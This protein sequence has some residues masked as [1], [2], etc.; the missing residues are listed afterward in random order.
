MNHSLVFVCEANVCRS[1]YMAFVF[2]KA[3][4]AAGV[5]GEWS[6]SSSGV[7]VSPGREICVVA[8]EMMQEVD[9]GAEAAASHRSTPLDRI[10]LSGQGLIIVATGQERGI[11]AKTA[12]DARARTFMLREAIAL[13]EAARR[14]AEPAGADL[15][16]YAALLHA[17]RG[18]LAVPRSRYGWSRGSDPWDTPDRHGRRDAAHRSML[19]SV[20]QDVL[21]FHAQVAN[22]LGG[23]SVS[24]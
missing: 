5:G 6:I 3:A 18:L 21:A 24:G 16:H 4:R 12:P 10:D 11:V 23:A 2:G 22:F 13:G 20:R 19:R 17:Q 7:A 9:G 1:P 15:A 8:R 14:G